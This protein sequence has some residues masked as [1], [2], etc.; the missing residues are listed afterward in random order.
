MSLIN[1]VILSESMKRASEYYLNIPDHLIIKQEQSTFQKDI[2]IASTN[3]AVREFISLSKN[4]S[5][6]DFNSYHIGA[7]IREI[8]EPQSLDKTYEVTI[9]LP[10][11]SEFDCR[12][13]GPYAT[14]EEATHVLWSNRSYYHEQW[15]VH[16]EQW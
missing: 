16:A 10:Y 12:A 5:S 1:T 11:N 6:D 7:I 3:G 14:L 15:D 9:M 2:L 8:Q 4:S 13:F